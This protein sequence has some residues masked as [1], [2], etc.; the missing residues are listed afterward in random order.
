MIGAA[1][2]PGMREL[3]APR[4]STVSL[5]RR[6]PPPTGERPRVSLQVLLRVLPR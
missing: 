1:A 3:G 5:P 4:I 2:Q 6:P